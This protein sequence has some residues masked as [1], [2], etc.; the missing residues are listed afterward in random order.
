VKYKRYTC[1]FITN[2]DNAVMVQLNLNMV[3][4]KLILPNLYTVKNCIIL[5]P[6]DN[7]E[8]LVVSF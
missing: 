4:Y 1:T 8:Q 2:D 3:Q 6:M 5:I 7:K